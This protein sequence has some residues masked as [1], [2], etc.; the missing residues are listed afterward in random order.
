MPSLLVVKESELRSLVGLDR[1]GLA[2]VEDGFTRLFRGEAIV[3]PPMGIDVPAREAEVHV[4]SAYV[5]GLPGFAV[6]V[7][8]GFYGNL[9]RG[10]PVSSG[11]M[12]LLSA[13]TG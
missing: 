1:E 5:S 10:L 3:P 4:K 12:L 6:K 2:A 11:M 8:S 9:A 7:A 13:E